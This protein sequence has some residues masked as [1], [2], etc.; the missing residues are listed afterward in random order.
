M[1]LPYELRA[2]EMALKD[3]KGRNIAEKIDELTTDVDSVVGFDGELNVNITYNSSTGK[4][5]LSAQSAANIYNSAEG[6]YRATTG[7]CIIKITY[8][9]PSSRFRNAY[10]YMIESGR[11]I[12]FLVEEPGVA[13]IQ[14][15]ENISG[16]KLYKHLIRRNPQDTMPFTFISTNA[17]AFTSYP[18]LTTA[19]GIVAAFGYSSGTEVLLVG[20]VYQGFQIYVCVSVSGSGEERTAE[21]KLLNT[22]ALTFYTDNVTP[23]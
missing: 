17:D 8:T 18:G 19:N 1:P 11:N 23:L 7:Y 6:L 3:S 15:S 16:T 9:G 20:S 10:V 4:Y 22:S 13:V 2:V 5:T 21:L 14:T 12:R